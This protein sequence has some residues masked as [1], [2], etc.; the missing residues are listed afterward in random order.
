MRAVSGGLVGIDQEVVTLRGP[1]GT[2]GSQYDLTG[3]SD[4]D[5]ANPKY[6]IQP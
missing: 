4:V 5:Q 3:R 2:L 1:F 6:W